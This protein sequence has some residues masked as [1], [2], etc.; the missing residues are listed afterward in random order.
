[1]NYYSDPTA[2]LAL[3]SINSEFTRLEKKAKRLRKLY[4]EGKLSNEALDKAHLQFKGIYRY[5]LEIVLN[6]EHQ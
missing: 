1:M 6:E 5:V 2:S 3:R 4:E